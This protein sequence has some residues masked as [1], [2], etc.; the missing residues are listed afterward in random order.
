MKNTN[1]N[2]PLILLRIINNKGKLIHCKVTRKTRRI[3]STLEADNFLNCLFIVSVKYPDGGK[4]QGE[5]KSKKEL[6]TALK[7]FLEK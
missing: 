4:N 5:Y 7:A 6:I 3:Y 1:I 2:L